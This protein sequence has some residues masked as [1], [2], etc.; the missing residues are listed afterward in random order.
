MKREEKSAIIDGLTKRLNEVRHFYLTDISDM[1]SVE[2]SELRRICFSKGVELVVVKN[3]LLKKALEQFDGDFK[4]LE[5]VMTQHTSLML[6]ETPNV[7]AK[8]IKEFRRKHKKP[9]LKGAFVEES[10]YLGDTSV[11]ALASLKSK[12]ELIADVVA[13]LQSPIKTVLSGLQSGSNIITGVLKTLENRQ[14]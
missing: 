1:N 6:C 11:D 10:V 7:P 13:L 8:L 4:A 2:T 3:T 12:N 5:G 9:I 14:E